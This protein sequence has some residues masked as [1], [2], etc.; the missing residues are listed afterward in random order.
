MNALILL[1]ML[2]TLTFVFLSVR[3]FTRWKRTKWYFPLGMAYLLNSILFPATLYLI[4]AEKAGMFKD[5]VSGQAVWMNLI[6]AAAGM[7]LW[8]AMH[9]K[10][11]NWKEYAPLGLPLLMTLIGLIVL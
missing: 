10:E 7:G 4:A 5:N 6:P 9:R 11:P 1:W 3:A 8:Y 2:P